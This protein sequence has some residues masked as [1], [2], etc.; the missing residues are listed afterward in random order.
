MPRYRPRRYN[1][2]KENH[3]QYYKIN[4]YSDVSHQYYDINMFNNNTGYDNTGAVI[5]ILSSQP[6]IFNQM[7]E[8]PYLNKP[9]DYSVSVVK[10][11]LD[12][13]SFPNQ[14]VQPLIG[15]QK[16]INDSYQTVYTV[17]LHDGGV[18]PAI[19]VNI[20]WKPADATLTPPTTGTQLV[21]PSMISN[22][23]FWNYSYQYFL[24]QINEQ[25]NIILANPLDTLYF[26]Y[27]PVTGL[28]YL[29]AAMNWYNVPQYRIYVNEQLYNLLAGFTYKFYLSVPSQGI[30]TA[31][32]QLI[33]EADIGLTNVVP[34]DLDFNIPAVQANFIKMTQSYPSVQ[35]WNPATSIVFTSK[36]LGVV[37]DDEMTPFIYGLNPNPPTNN[38]NISCNISEYFLGRRADPVIIY[39]D[40]LYLFKQLLGHIPQRDLIIETFWKDDFG[41]LHP[42]FLES[43]SNYSLKLLFRKNDFGE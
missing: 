4:N 19:P 7:R 8:R 10:F 38:S 26:K 34:I 36:S 15:L 14:I 28:I 43:G 16:N 1:K 11:T 18:G 41:N 13:N 5:P 32:Y 42:F 22:E 29:E 24:D 30:N 31:V 12:S 21:D 25:I 9:D 2:P 3:N 27:N 37:A 20:L 23:Y 17:Y 33:V 6:S 35:L 39:K 40:Y